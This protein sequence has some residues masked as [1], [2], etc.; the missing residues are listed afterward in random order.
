MAVVVV[1]DDEELSSDVVV[2]DVCWVLS[3]LSSVLLSVLSSSLSVVVRGGASTHKSPSL[4]DTTRNRVDTFPMRVSVRARL[5][6]PTRCRLTSP[7][8]WISVNRDP[9]YTASN[10]NTSANN[11]L[12]NVAVN[13]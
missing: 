8:A 2:L 7:N 9:T 1:G 12:P 3:V 4:N 5:P 13:G 11:T 6:F 10:P